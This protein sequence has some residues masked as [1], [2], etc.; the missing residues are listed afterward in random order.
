MNGPTHARIYPAGKVALKSG[1]RVVDPDWFKATPWNNEDVEILQRASDA[2]Q[3]TC[4]IL[5]TRPYFLKRVGKA[6][7]GQL[8]PS[9]CTPLP[10]QSRCDPARAGPCCLDSSH[11]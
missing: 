9:C 7:L 11:G 10:V 8:S 1:V 6:A 4:T 2:C 5:L 3:G